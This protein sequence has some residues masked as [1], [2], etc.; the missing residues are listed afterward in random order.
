MANNTD[1]CV[2]VRELFWNYD[3]RIRIG[4]NFRVVIKQGFEKPTEPQPCAHRSF[5][6]RPS[7]PASVKEGVC[8]ADGAEI[9]ALRK[10]VKRSVTTA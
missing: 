2:I 5:P 6:H 10:H 1:L 7:V 9:L 8:V 3:I 4:N